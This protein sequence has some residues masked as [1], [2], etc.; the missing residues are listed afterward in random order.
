MK[1][2]ISIDDF[3]KVEIK[4]GTV[5]AAERVPETDKLYKCTVD[6]GEETPRTIVSGIAHLREVEDIVGTQLPYVTN[7]APRMIKG[8][9]SNGMLLAVGGDEAFALLHPDLEVPSGTAGK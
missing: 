8:I 6:V 7:L 4:I 9:E 2:Q 5:L 1:E 3:A